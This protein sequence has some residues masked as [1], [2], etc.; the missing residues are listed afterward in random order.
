MI[1]DLVK[2]VRTCRK[3]ERRDAA[4]RLAETLGEDAVDELKRM[5][6]GERRWFLSMYC[7][8]D[9]LIGVEALGKTRAIEAYDFLLYISHSESVDHIIP[10]DEMGNTRVVTSGA[11]YPNAQGELRKSLYLGLGE[12]YSILENSLSQLNVEVGK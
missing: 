6:N 4:I 5:V 9:Q 12:S 8:A 10:C 2:R 7:Y 11:F 3:E 1:H